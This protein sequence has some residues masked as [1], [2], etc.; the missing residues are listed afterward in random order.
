MNAR[1]PVVFLFLAVAAF[2][3]GDSIP[4]GEGAK[5]VEE[6]ADK[7]E[8]YHQS[9][10]APERDPE[11]FIEIRAAGASSDSQHQVSAKQFAKLRAHREEAIRALAGW[12]KEKAATQRLRVLRRR[13]HRDDARRGGPLHDR[14]RR[15]L[16]V[17]REVLQLPQP[18]QHRPDG[19]ERV[20]GEPGVPVLK[21]RALT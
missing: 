10:F 12:L 14:P 16:V 13:D 17:L 9:C 20:A 5:L 3:Q 11:L 19:P 21:E 4:E 1:T 15:L 6:I 7:P 18:C 2:A 8:I